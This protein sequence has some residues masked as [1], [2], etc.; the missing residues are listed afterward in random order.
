QRAFSGNVRIQ[1][2]SIASA[3]DQQHSFALDLLTVAGNIDAPLDRWSPEALKARDGV[4]KFAALTYGNNT[5]NDFDASWKIDGH[6]L[7][8]DHFTAKM[9]AGSISDAPAFDLVT[10]A[11]PARDF[12]IQNIDM[13]QA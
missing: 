10:L 3:P 4:L 13:H 1:D 7:S 11:M 8:A 12:R 9:F 6:L 5:V 2:L